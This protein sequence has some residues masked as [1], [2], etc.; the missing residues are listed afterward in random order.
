MH[1]G[2]DA[3]TTVLRRGGVRVN[4]CAFTCGCVC[5]VPSGPMRPL[6]GASV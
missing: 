5:V 4:T 3:F 6:S 2:V 1:A